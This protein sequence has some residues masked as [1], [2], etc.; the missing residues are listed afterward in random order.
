MREKLFSSASRRTTVLVCTVIVLAAIAA[1]HNSFSNPFIF[2][3]LGAIAQNTSIRHLWPIWDAL[4]PPQGGE[5][6]SGRPLVNLS[7]AVNYALGGTAVWGYHALNLAVHILA[8]L[9]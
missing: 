4:S 3:D 5:P 6:V 9:T 7:L 2:D 1:Y 8:A